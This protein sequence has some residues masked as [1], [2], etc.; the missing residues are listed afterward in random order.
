MQDSESGR[1]GWTAVFR[2]RPDRDEIPAF[3]SNNS[4]PSTVASRSKCVRVL[5]DHTSK[6]VYTE[7]FVRQGRQ[8]YNYT[9]KSTR[10]EILANLLVE[11]LSLLPH[12]LKLTLKPSVIYFIRHL[13]AI[14]AYFIQRSRRISLGRYYFFYTFPKGQSGRGVSLII[15]SFPSSA[16]F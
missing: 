9:F 7:C 4:H 1:C 13:R 14:S 2:L 16:E 15:H 3:Y 6:F 12:L 11:L 8:L 5:R 10:I